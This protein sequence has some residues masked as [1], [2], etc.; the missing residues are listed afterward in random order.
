MNRT[1]GTISIYSIPLK[2]FQNIVIHLS[3]P[4]HRVCKALKTRRRSHN[5]YEDRMFELLP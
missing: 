1:V 2:L 3:V 5:G 4:L